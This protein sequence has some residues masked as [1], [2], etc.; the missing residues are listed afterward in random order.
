MKDKNRIQSTET[1]K[2]NVGESGQKKIYITPQLFIY[3]P[4]EKIT[5]LLISGASDT[6]TGTAA[7]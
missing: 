4:I 3:G 2:H 6:L 1:R 7:V 5:N